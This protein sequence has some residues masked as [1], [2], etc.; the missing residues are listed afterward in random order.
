MHAQIQ[1]IEI[2]F[3]NG[4]ELAYYN[5]IN[6]ALKIDSSERKNF[7]EKYESKST[8]E[9]NIKKEIQ[10]LKQSLLLSVNKS[11]KEVILIINEI[12][13]LEIILKNNQRDFILDCMN[14][15]DE[16]RAIYYSIYNKNFRKKYKE[17]TSKN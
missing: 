17:Y 2:D 4:Y 12:T 11:R 9:K 16:K 14:I 1:D 15:L 13:E 7:W 10:K 5:Y 3:S 6:T 8:D